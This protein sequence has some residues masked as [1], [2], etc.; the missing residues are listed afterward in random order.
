MSKSTL[1]A[2]VVDRDIGLFWLTRSRWLDTNSLLR[3]RF[4][5]IP[6]PIRLNSLGQSTWLFSSLFTILRSSIS[7]RASKAGSLK[8]SQRS[9]YDNS[10]GSLHLNDRNFTNFCWTRSSLSR[11]VWPLGDHTKEQYSSLERTKV[12]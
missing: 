11:I 8:Y 3:D 4:I 9:A 1:L 12:W 10:D 7:R 5:G 2:N 6:K